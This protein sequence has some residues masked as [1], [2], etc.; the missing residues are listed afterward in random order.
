MIDVQITQDNKVRFQKALW[1]ESELLL[2]KCFNFDINME[3]N[4]IVCN[5]LVTTK[6]ALFEFI[7]ISFKGFSEN[8]SEEHRRNR[9][10]D[11]MQELYSNMDGHSLAIASQKLPYFDMLMMHQREG[12]SESFYKQFTF[13]AWE[14]RLGKSIAAASISRIHQIPRT[15]IVCPS[16]VKWGWYRDLTERFGYNQLYFTI[17]DASKSR[18]IRAFSERFVIVNY[19]ILAKF[20]KEIVN[21]GVGHF[22]LDEIHKCKSHTSLRF[23]NLKKIIDQFPNSR[24]TMLSGTPIK[25]RVN[26]VFAYFKMIGHELGRSHKAFLDEYTT[27]VS[28]RGGDRVNGGRNLQ[29]LSIKMSNLMSI[30][31]QAEC[32]DLPEKTFMSY[33]FE[34][35]DYRDEYNK[36]IEELSELKD[37]GS[38]TGNLHSLN[39]I[40]SKAKLKGVKELIDSILELGKKVVVFG[41]YKEPLNELEKYYGKACVKI[42]G[43]VDSWGRGERIQKFTK[44]PECT[45]FLGNMQAAG[46]GTNLSIADEIVVLNFPLTPSELYQAIERCTDMNKKK[47]VGVHYTFCDDSID[48]YIYDIIIDKERDVNAVLHQGKEVMQRE[49]IAETLMKKLLKRE[50][51]III[52]DNG[53]TD[54]E[55]EKNANIL[56]E[57]SQI[58]AIGFSSKG[59]PIPIIDDLPDFMNNG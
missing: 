26:D 17:L 47:S 10:F 32:L 44:D 53:L 51:T 13:L 15:V 56:K 20:E 40:T 7:R 27:T 1:H 14:M 28:S 18:T 54:E 46:E 16:G 45:V 36:I 24:I 11:S 52:E 29:D 38:L 33:R 21:G 35:D 34:M 57:M 48:E 6:R 8:I 2:A 5:P 43:S 9:F 23:R 50:P 31:T 41:S 3:T 22:I 42:D 58:G 55:N 19:D 25:N 39:I 30:K 12:I 37:I 59:N 4:V 49:N